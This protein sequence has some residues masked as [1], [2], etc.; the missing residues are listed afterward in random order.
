MCKRTHVPAGLAD[1]IMY[2]PVFVIFPIRL[3]HGLLLHAHILSKRM[4]AA[5]QLITAIFLMPY[6]NCKAEEEDMI[7][8]LCCEI[9]SSFLNC[10]IWCKTIA[11]KLAL[12]L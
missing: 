5:T 6:T 11:L 1:T 4:T 3:G 12:G 2:S 9:F 7:V 10:F 8:V